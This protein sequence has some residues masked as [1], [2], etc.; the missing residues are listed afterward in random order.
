MPRNEDIHQ[1]HALVYL[2]LGDYPKAAAVAHTVL[3]MGPGWNWSVVQSFYPS[4][5]IY[6]QQ[7]RALEHSITEHGD[8]AST[9]FL[10]GYEYLMLGHFKAAD[11]QFQR[12]VALEPRDTLAKNILNGLEQRPGRQGQRT[13]GNGQQS[14]VKSGDAGRL[15]S[16]RRTAGEQCRVA[17]D[18]NAAERRCPRHSAGAAD[19]TGTG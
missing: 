8:Q 13:A 10:L 3:D 15:R 7:L 18:R 17:D 14:A 2:A 12:V 19:T 1:F 11:R 16:A 4:P 5:D 6:T 9:R